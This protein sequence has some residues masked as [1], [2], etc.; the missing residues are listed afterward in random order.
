[1]LIF[2]ICYP[3][4]ELLNYIYLD[5]GVVRFGSIGIRWSIFDLCSQF[6]E[7][8]SIH[9]FRT[10]V[11]V[12]HIDCA[13]TCAK[14]DK[15]MPPKDTLLEWMQKRRQLLLTFHAQPFQFNKIWI[16][17]GHVQKTFIMQL[18]HILLHTYPYTF[19]RCSFLIFCSNFISSLFYTFFGYFY[20]S[21]LLFDSHNCA[22]THNKTPN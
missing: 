3:P 19:Q 5:F 18:F 6:V 22:R 11:Y 12:G 1:M 21:A 13:V 9:T 7:Q 20:S 10:R 17:I 8:G 4:D 2:R 14:D 16:F 15:I